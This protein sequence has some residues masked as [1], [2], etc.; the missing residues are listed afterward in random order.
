GSHAV[1]N[2]LPIAIDLVGLGRQGMAHSNIIAWRNLSAS[3]GSESLHMIPFG[4]DLDM[5]MTP[6]ISQA[7]LVQ[8]LQAH[9]IVVQMQEILGLAPT[10]SSEQVKAAVVKLNADLQVARAA[11]A[12]R[13]AGEMIASYQPSIPATVRPFVLQGVQGELATVTG[14]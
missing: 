2:F 1:Q 4:E 7:E 8:A 13:L 11:E 6:P 3:G 12:A 9:E 14:V 5:T 10:A